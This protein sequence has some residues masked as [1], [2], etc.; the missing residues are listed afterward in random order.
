ML[1]LLLL[2]AGL[3]AG[4]EVTR[5]TLKIINVPNPDFTPRLDKG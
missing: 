2:L 4:Q 3:A 5:E 1:Q